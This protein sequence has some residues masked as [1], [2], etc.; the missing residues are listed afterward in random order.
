[1]YT[2]VRCFATSLS[3]DSSFAG[4]ANATAPSTASERSL[5]N[6]CCTVWTLEITSNSPLSS[7]IHTS[8]PRA[9]PRKLEKRKHQVAA[10]AAPDPHFPHFLLIRTVP[11]WAFQFIPHLVRKIARQGSSST[12]APGTIRSGLD[13][14]LAVIHGPANDAMNTQH[15][16]WLILGRCTY[17]HGPA[18]RAKQTCPRH[19]KGLP[20]R[21]ATQPGVDMLT[22]IPK[23]VS[24]ERRLFGREKVPFC[25]KLT[26][27]KK[28]S[29][30]VKFQ[31]LPNSKGLFINLIEFA[32]FLCGW[33]EEKQS[34][35]SKSLM[36]FNSWQHR[37]HEGN[38]HPSALRRSSNGCMH[39]W[40]GVDDL[41]IA[42]SCQCL[43]ILH[44]VE[45]G[46]WHIMEIRCSDS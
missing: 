3:L 23:S 41:C 18:W 32:S 16:L 2:Q 15:V 43:V 20:P 40:L 25:R 11:L 5:W 29:L 27:Q 42:Y 14:S 30:D 37:H 17:R 4:L 31:C 22:H 1:M 9:A 28:R 7:A 38:R 34:K 21:S 19:R 36:L 46:P 12:G 24:I 26:L 6:G 45:F 8:L 39:L 13:G 44:H 10:K 33:G 35:Q